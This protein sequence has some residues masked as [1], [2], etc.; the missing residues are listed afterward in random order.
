ME[1]NV[2][3]KYGAG[4]AALVVV[5]LI[6]VDVAGCVVPVPAKLAIGCKLETKTHE[7]IET[8]PEPLPNGDRQHGPTNADRLCPGTSR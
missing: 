1:K 4:V 5:V 3:Q 7:K 6:L 8:Y 2:I